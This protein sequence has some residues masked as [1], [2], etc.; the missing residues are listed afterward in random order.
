MS[1]VTCKGRTMNI[2]K[3]NKILGTLINIILILFALHITPYTL[4]V[5]YAEEPGRIQVSVPSPAELKAGETIFFQTFVV[6]E[7]ND[8]WG[9][10]TYSGFAQVYGAQKDF[11]SA[12][13]PVYGTESVNVGGSALFI[14]PFIVPL[15]F[16]G[17]YFFKMVF[18]YKNSG[19]IIGSHSAFSVIP[20]PKVDQPP[21]IQF[22]NFDLSA[23]QGEQI[24]LKVKITDDKGI[25]KVVVTYQFPGMNSRKTQDME[26]LSGTRQDGV[27]LFKTGSV[28]KTGNVVF[29]VSATDS[30]GQVSKAEYQFSSVTK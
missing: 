28:A 16:G 24:N 4:H 30:K 21:E 6:N 12:T 20:R 10:G 26:L 23:V 14:I 25:A 27:W 2:K 19:P 5:S 29:A 18:N 3:T 11:I 9:P 8:T 1:R 7:G 13:E 17:Q 22:M 15:D